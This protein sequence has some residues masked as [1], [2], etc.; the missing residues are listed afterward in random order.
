MNKCQVF[1]YSLKDITTMGN[2]LHIKDIL[3]IN[4]QKN[5]K[6]GDIIWRGG[7]RDTDTL[8]VGVNGIL[9]KNLDDH[10]DGELT[11]PKCVYSHIKNYQSF[12]QLEEL[13]FI[14]FEL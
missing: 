11:I 7:Y 5:A 3:D 14:N 4:I 13:P 10:K 1:D 6:L 12:Y 2:P 8:I 9:I